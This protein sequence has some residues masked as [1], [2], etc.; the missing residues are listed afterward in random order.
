MVQYFD[1]SIKSWD[2]INFI[3]LV[4]Q[5]LW[6]F[7]GGETNACYNAVDRHVANGNGQRTAIIHDSPV[8]SSQQHVTYAEL[9]EQV[10]CPPLGTRRTPT[11][12][13]KSWIL[14][15][16][17]YMSCVGEDGCCVVVTKPI[18]SKID[19]SR[20]AASAVDVMKTNKLPF[21]LFW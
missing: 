20:D 12:S 17:A 6:R 19:S 21:I 13:S 5:C 1:Q 11:P 8:T 2:L 3:L 18:N 14:L 4:W 10:S 16:S 15:I 9:Q 7:V